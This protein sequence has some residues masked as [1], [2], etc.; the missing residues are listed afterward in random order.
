MRT[1]V[2]AVRVEEDSQHSTPNIQEIVNFY[3]VKNIETAI[4][5]TTL[6]K[7]KKIE[8]INHIQKRLEIN[9]KMT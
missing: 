4:Q 8:V 3:Y 7:E 2:F 6:S 1:H 5:K 9:S